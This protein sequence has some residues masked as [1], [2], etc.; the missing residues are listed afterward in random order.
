MFQELPKIA[1]VKCC[2]EY[3]LYFDGE[4][5]MKRFASV[6][7]AVLNAAALEPDAKVSE[8]GF[9]TAKEASLSL[10]SMAIRGDLEAL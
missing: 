1:I 9:F 4:R 5:E 8:I 10:A 2:E 7:A 3:A 6:Q